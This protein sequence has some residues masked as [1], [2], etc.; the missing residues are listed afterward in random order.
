M[1]ESLKRGKDALN[2]QNTHCN[3]FWK[4]VE[5]ARQEL[6]GGRGGEQGGSMTAW[7]QFYDDHIFIKEN[8]NILRHYNNKFLLYLKADH[9]RVFLVESIGTFSINK[10]DGS[11]NITFK[12]NWRFF[13]LCRVYFNSLKIANVGQFPWSWFLWDR[14]Q[15]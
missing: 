8:Y 5:T 3:A 9:W 4:T 7:L 11:E 6:V 14:T 15:V 1:G 12:M 13:Q 2:G 10:G